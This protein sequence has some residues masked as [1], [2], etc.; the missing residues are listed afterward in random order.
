MGTPLKEEV[1]T[2]SQFVKWWLTGVRGYRLV[3]M[4]RTPQQAL[5][6]QIHYKNIW[7]LEKDPPGKGN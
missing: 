4:V 6:G 3:R 1:S 5:F 7:W 2:G